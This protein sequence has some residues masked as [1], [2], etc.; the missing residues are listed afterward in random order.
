MLQDYNLVM[1]KQNPL[2]IAQW[3]ADKL[4]PLQD[5]SRIANPMPDS[6]HISTRFVTKIY[7]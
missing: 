7:V 5:L 2:E 4:I 1:P 3:T 6:V